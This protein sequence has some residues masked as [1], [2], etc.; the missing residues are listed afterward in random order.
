MGVTTTTI[1]NINNPELMNKVLRHIKEPIIPTTVV[2]NEKNA[3]MF[4]KRVGFPV[5]IKP[6]ASLTKTNRIKC[7]NE[8]QL[9]EVFEATY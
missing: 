3:V 5:L 1:H 2:E 7:D 6:I 4:A 9:Q 8:H